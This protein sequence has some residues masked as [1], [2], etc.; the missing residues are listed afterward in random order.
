MV[1]GIHDITSTTPFPT[2][3]SLMLWQVYHY[4]TLC[5]TQLSSQQ[6]KRKK[7]YCR[8][9]GVSSGATS[10][11]SG[12]NLSYWHHAQTP[13]PSSTEWHHQ[14]PTV[15]STPTSNTN[16]MV[17]QARKYTTLNRSQMKNKSNPIMR[18]QSFQIS[19][20]SSQFSPSENS[21]FHC[22]STNINKDIS[23]VT[24]DYPKK[25]AIIFFVILKKKLRQ[26]K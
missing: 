24:I 20:N 2:P 3:R 22:I 9:S 19:H 4:I 13:A 12:S 21:A 25:L 11:S 5:L 23:Q 10:G 17:D 14:G 1:N 18:T 26:A 6:K 16:N 15:A 8:T 7:C